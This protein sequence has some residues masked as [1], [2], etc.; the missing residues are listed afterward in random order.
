M[1]SLERRVDSLERENRR[2]RERLDWWL[3][4]ITGAIYAAVVI[5]L[6]L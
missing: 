1:N 5:Y 3:S 6:V 2:R 4:I